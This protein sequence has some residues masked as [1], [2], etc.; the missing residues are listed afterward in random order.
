MNFSPVILGWHR[1]F[2]E[3]EDLKEQSFIL[4]VCVYVC[5]F[6]SFKLGP[7]VKK[8]QV[9]KNLEFLQVFIISYLFHFDEI[10]MRK[11]GNL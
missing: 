3:L 7:R 8:G 4:C 6:C 10:R 9:F 2:G 11:T 5:V 1:I